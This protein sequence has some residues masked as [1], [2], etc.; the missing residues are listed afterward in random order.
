MTNVL[1]ERTLGFLS[2]A[3]ACD[4]SNFG[5]T[6]C[7]IMCLCTCGSGAAAGEKKKEERKKSL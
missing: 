7:P 4:G 6:G 1:Q 5:N 3:K 2:L